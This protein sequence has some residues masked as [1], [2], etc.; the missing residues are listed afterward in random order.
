MWPRLAALKS[1]SKWVW[2]F[3]AVPFQSPL[4][5]MCTDS[6]WVRSMLMCM[7]LDVGQVSSR[8]CPRCASPKRR[9]PT[10]TC[11]GGKL[12]GATP[13]AAASVTPGGVL[14]SF[15]DSAAADCPDVSA[16]P[17]LPGFGQYKRSKRATMPRLLMSC[18][19]TVTVP[20]MSVPSTASFNKV[21]VG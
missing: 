21:D 7:P 9:S 1:I 20:F 4:A 17:S 10:H 5:D 19:G 13:T 2:L 14:V 16:P 3:C 18:T 11:K 12:D 8:A 6:D 15:P